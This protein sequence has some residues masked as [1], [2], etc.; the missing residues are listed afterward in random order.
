MELLALY[1]EYEDNENAG[2]TIL[3]LGVF[4]DLGKLGEFLQRAEDYFKKDN[5]VSL[6]IRRL[7]VNP[8]TK[9][10]G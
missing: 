5:T 8:A 6:S 2:T 1:L 9:G 3:G 7:K 10:T 4:T